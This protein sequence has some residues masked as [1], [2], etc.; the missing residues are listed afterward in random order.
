MT[1]NERPD[2]PRAVLLAT[3]LSARCD[4][5]MARAVQLCRHWNARLVAVSVAPREDATIERELLPPPDWARPFAP[6]ED[7][8]LQLRREL[9][10]AGVEHEAVIE[11]G[12]VGAALDRVARE[13]GCSLIVTG[14]RH[15]G[16]LLSSLPGTTVGWLSRNT[17]HPLL[18]V[19]QRVHGPYRHVACATD[20]SEAALQ[21]LRTTGRWFGEDAR[22][23]ALVHGLDVPMLGFVDSDERRSELVRDAS[24]DAHQQADAALD[25]ATLSAASVQRI[26][27]RMDPARLV[28]EY[29]R[30]RGADLVVAGTQG[31]GAL[32]GLLLGSVAQR[33]L[34]TAGCDVLL[35]RAAAA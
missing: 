31:R 25:A 10:A 21:A 4:R 17:P 32:G 33:I 18:I 8:R 13:H 22:T 27:E 3:D 19:R 29:V 34:E 14:V 35:V 7:A 12:P 16:P 24:R 1:V 15:R 20:F 11:T 26:I 9:E 5:A 30:S 23:L 28:E 2:V 6:F